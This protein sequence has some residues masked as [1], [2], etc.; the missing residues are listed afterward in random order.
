[1]GANPI[2]IPHPTNLALFG[3]KITLYRFNQGGLILLQGAQTEAGGLSP[4]HFNHCWHCWL[5]NRKGIRSVKKLAVGLL[6]AM[7]WLE[8]CTSYSSSW[9]HHLHHP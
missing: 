8:L 6:L 2:P 1:M 3:H 9:H 5:G 4:P 7:I